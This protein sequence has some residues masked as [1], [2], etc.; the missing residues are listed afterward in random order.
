MLV[1]FTSESRVQWNV[2][3]LLGLVI[4][5]ALEE[6]AGG[7]VWVNAMELKY[8]EE[9]ELKDVVGGVDVVEH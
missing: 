4:A 2:C 5:D 9:I 8:V 7:Y 3:G 1:E 6:F